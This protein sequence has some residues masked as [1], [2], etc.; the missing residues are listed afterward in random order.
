MTAPSPRRTPAP[1]S[2][3]T[4]TPSPSAPTARSSCTTTTSSRSSPSSTA[5]VSRARRARQGRRRV[6]HVH[7]DPGRQRVHPCGAVPARHDD[8]DAR[9]LLLR[10]RRAG[11]ARHLARPP[12]LRAEVLR[13]RATTTSSATTRPCSS[14][15][16]A[17]SSPTSSARRSVCRARTCATTTCSGTSGRSPRVG[18]PGDLAH[19]RPRPPV[20]LA[21]HGRVRLAHL[22]VDQRGGRAVLG[23]VPLQDPAGHQEPHGRRGLA[24]RRVGLDHHIRDLY[25]HI[26]GATSRAGRSRSRSCRTRTPRPTGSTRSTS[27]RCGRTPTTR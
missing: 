7:R 23:Q 27:R 18:A 25:E 14:C 22:S 13:P 21:P 3:R 10:R 26:E 1:P 16:T 11:L 4:P 9:A 15:A 6:R 20:E 8:R 19:G 12:R 5:S 24:A 2:P 17:S